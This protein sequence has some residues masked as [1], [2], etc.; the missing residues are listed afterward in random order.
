MPD[1]VQAIANSRQAVRVY[2]SVA[3]GYKA[4]SAAPVATLATVATSGAY[5]DLSGKPTLGSAAATS[6]TAYATA[7][8]GTKADSAVQPASLATVATS[9]AYADLTG[10]PTLG[11]AAAT[12][13]TAYATATQ[14]VKADSALQSSTG[15]ITGSS[16]KTYVWTADFTASFGAITALTGTAVTQTITGLSTND[17]VHCECVSAPPSGYVPPNARV[18]ASNTLELYFNTPVALGITLGS[19]NFRTTVIR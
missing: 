9:G 3:Q 15:I 19:L 14:G 1:R 4:D 10:K 2:A 7:A 17:Q 13:S 5:A 11:S 12:S 16:T 18:S 6:S 8:Q